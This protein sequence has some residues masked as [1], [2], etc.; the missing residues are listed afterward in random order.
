MLF[1][2]H[3]LSKRRGSRDE[4]WDRIRDDR[5]GRAAKL[6]VDVRS[7][8][9]ST[10]RSQAAGVQPAGRETGERES[11]VERRARRTRRARGSGE[12]VSGSGLVDPEVRKRRYAVVGRHREGAEES[13]SG[14]RPGHCP[15]RHRH[16]A[17]GHEVS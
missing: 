8:A 15:N 9:I 7:P 12:R 5:S 11:H 3:R 2:A 14:R 1:A 4:D 10:S 6:A 17:R 13:G 16:R